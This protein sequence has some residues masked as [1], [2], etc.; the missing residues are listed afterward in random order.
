[1]KGAAASQ[2]SAVARSGFSGG[3]ASEAESIVGQA[4]TQRAAVGGGAWR[5]KGDDHGALLAKLK[6]EPA[7]LSGTLVSLGV[8]LPF[9]IS[10]TEGQYLKRSTPFVSPPLANDPG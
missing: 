6:G 1:M 10:L 4:R 8:G 7:G 9:D 2:P 5:V 3:A